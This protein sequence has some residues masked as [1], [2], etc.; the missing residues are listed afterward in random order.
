[1]SN[2]CRGVKKPSSSANQSFCTSDWPP[3]RVCCGS[4][5]GRSSSSLQMMGRRAFQPQLATLPQLLQ[6]PL[7]Q[8]RSCYQGWSQGKAGEH[9]GVRGALA[10][11]SCSFCAE[12]LAISLVW[13]GSRG[14]RNNGPIW[15]PNPQ[16]MS[17][18]LRPWHEVQVQYA[19][20]PPQFLGK[21]LDMHRTWVDF[22]SIFGRSGSF[23]CYRI[24][25]LFWAVSV[26]PRSISS[27]GESSFR[28][29]I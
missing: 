25:I 18:A 1:M 8:L 6:Q 10:L 3:Q 19:L 20:S 24:S 21:E 23:L 9:S 22:R 27:C 7:R 4:T 5:W 14:L 17:S 29:L 16:L 28:H 12:S 11:C 13:L 15:A 26:V 2:I